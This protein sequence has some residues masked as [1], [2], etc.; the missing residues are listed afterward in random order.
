M[1]KDK[2]AGLIQLTLII[3][4]IAGSFGISKL[5]ESEYEPP[6]NENG[7][8]RVLVVETETVKPGMHR[9]TFD[10]TGI[11]RAKNQIR[12]VP[13]VSGRIIKVH[14]AFF[15]DGAFSKGE[16][17]FQVEPR[18]YELENR[19]LEAEV[20]RAR[21]LLQ[22]EKAEADAALAE[23]NQVNGDMPAPDLVARRPQMDEAR[24]NLLS[25]EALLENAQLDLERTRFTLP[26][27]GRVLTSDIAVGQYVVAGQA[28]GTVF[29]TATLEVQAS[30][31]DRRLEWLLRT[32][33]PAIDISVDY[34]A[35]TRHYTGMLNRAAASLDAT[36]R[37]ATVH[38]GFRDPAA[39]LL[40][41]V[42]ARIDITG[43]ELD[44]IT[45]IP[46]SALQSRN[47]V[48][49]VAPDNT[50]IK[51]L[52]DILYLDQDYVAVR[53]LEQESVVVTSRIS[54]GMDGM[55]VQIG[56]DSA[57]RPAQE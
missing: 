10:T 34:L 7:A 18:D 28:Y 35:E 49:R 27:D 43:P 56:Q 52:P 51:W 19:R 5:L 29:D 53:G 2:R 46:S 38:F 36:T 16:T 42:F 50:L 21:T 22:M 9:I 47:I 30:L 3:I 20:A 33:T 8:P 45:L 26:F 12:I 55:P 23:W 14:D 25:A 31:N 11:V 15:N 37:F 6:G 40:P 48:W 54:G 13:E 41:G 44:S 17:L 32:A 24:A 39:D 4:F 1:N 57:T